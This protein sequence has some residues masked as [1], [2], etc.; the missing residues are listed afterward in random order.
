MHCQDIT[1]LNHKTR[2]FQ[3]NED[4]RIELEFIQAGS[5]RPPGATNCVTERESPSG[6][7]GVPGGHDGTPAHNN[8]RKDLDKKV[9]NST[10][11]QSV[12]GWVFVT[13]TWCLLRGTDGFFTFIEVYLSL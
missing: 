2:R 10:L 12:T 9:S 8:S 11:A 6:R 3:L 4:F 13:E 7:I 1:R 5:P